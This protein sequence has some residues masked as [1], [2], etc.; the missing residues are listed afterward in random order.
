MENSESFTD[1]HNVDIE[2]F[3]SQ[4]DV[5]S[6]SLNCDVLEKYY[7]KDNEERKQW[8]QLAFLRLST[9]PLGEDRDIFERDVQE[10]LGEVSH[11]MEDFLP[12]SAH[13]NYNILLVVKSIM[14]LILA[15]QRMSQR[16]NTLIYSNGDKNFCNFTIRTRREDGTQIPLLLRKY[17]Q[18][19]VQSD[20]M[21]EDICNNYEIGQYIGQLFQMHINRVMSVGGY[22]VHLHMGSFTESKEKQWFNNVEFTG[23]RS[24]SENGVSPNYFRDYFAYNTTQTLLDVSNEESAKK[25]WPILK[26]LELH[27]NA[28]SGAESLPDML[29]RHRP[30]V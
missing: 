25:T 29:P 24:N 18:S 10:Q 5:D 13:S 23:P 30:A 17:D 1:Q 22:Y 11:R 15:S 20:I 21:I 2:T 16:F 9:M 28:L 7:P 19:Q 8:L 4:H 27:V 14:Q 12:V 6:E 26:M 3:T